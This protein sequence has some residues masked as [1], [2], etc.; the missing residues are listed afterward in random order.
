MLFNYSCSTYG[1]SCRQIAA[2]REKDED[3]LSY[4]EMT[5]AGMITGFAQSPVRY[6]TL[7]FE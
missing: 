3:K 1:H 4:L 5:L 7:E 6:D 2:F